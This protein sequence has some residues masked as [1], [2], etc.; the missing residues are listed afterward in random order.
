MC[1]DLSVDIFP[2]A[3]EICMK[4]VKKI[5]FAVVGVFV[6]QEE[7]NTSIYLQC[8]GIDNTNKSDGES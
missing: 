4:Q 6:R 7:V 5:N 2:V 8:Y 1:T 3:V